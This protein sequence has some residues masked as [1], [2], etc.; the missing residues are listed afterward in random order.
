MNVNKRYLKNFALFL[1][2]LPQN[3]LGILIKIITKV[4]LTEKYSFKVYHWK[5]NGGISLGNYIFINKDST[6]TTALHEKGHQK[7]SLYLGWLYLIIIGLPSLIWAT[8][9]TLGLFSNV[10]YYW[11]YTEAWADKLSN[12]KRNE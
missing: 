6:L 1:W 3:I 9:K 8:L 7:Q 5:L 2:Q 12:I 10:S 4:E 11:F